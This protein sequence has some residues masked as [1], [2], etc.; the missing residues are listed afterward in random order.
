MTR[1]AICGNEWLLNGSVP[2]RG[3]AA[4]G[5]LMNL[6]AV[7][8][9][10][11]DS[12]R[13][14]FDP[15]ANTRAF[16]RMLPL[17]RNA[18]MRAITLNLQGG[19]PGYEG[20]VN[21][22]LNPDGTLRPGYMVRVARVIEACDDLGMAVIL[23]VYYQRQSGILADADAVR[24]GVY[25]TATWL[26]E[27]GYEHVLLEV[28]NE[29][30]HPGYKHDILK[31]PAGQ[32]E[33]MQIA[34]EANPLL[35]VS[36]STLG[37]GHVPDAVGEVADYVLI[38]FN[39]TP[40]EEIP[41]RVAVARRFGKPVMCNEDF[42]EDEEG[43]RAVRVCVAEHCSWGLM[44]QEHNQHLPFSFCGPDDDPVVYGALVALTSRGQIDSLSNC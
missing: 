41:L 7:N 40:V 36:T 44:L 32:V 24:S 30:G 11:E 37:H 38:H 8:S 3:A 17:Y 13:P 43:A 31:E 21:S 33:L 18:G 10:F 29:F 5:L 4:E 23:G 19:M 35:L 12:G 14:D 15:E 42:K 6:R 39:E 27:Q 22:A 1:I 2:Y 34:K 9:T 26:L 28:A 20:A 25:A 16:L